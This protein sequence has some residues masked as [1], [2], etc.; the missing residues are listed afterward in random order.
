[1]RTIANDRAVTAWVDRLSEAGG[2]LESVR[3]QILEAV[4]AL[5]RT[6]A[7]CW[8]TT[9]PATLMITGSV[10]QGLP[11]SIGAEFFRIELHEPDYL[12]LV[13]LPERTPPVGTLWSETGGH[14]ED[15]TRWR[16][17]FGPLGLGDEL[18]A[19]FV[20]GSACWGYLSLHRRRE[21]PQFGP[22]EIDVMATLA[23]AAAQALRHSHMRSA[24]EESGTRAVVLLAADRTPLAVSEEAE[25]LMADLEPAA[26]SRSDLPAAVYTAIGHL[27][28]GGSG[29]VTAVGAS[30]TWLVVRAARLT[31]EDAGWT[32]VTI[33]SAS[34][35]EARGHIMASWALT[36]RESEVA[37]M[38]LRGVS[39]RRIAAELFISP[40]TV[41]QHLKK[42][43]EKSGV[44]S[45]RDLVALVNAGS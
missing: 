13:D 4:F 39:T 11:H 37:A 18:R 42:V 41:Q 20:T 44:H 43:F 10:T 1:M 35:R 8:S 12:K 33:E 9:D 30:G 14:L 15:S 29:E 19:A 25:K 40:H 31:G 24:I 2:D 38:V 21:S 34:P 5:I 27:D 16:S 23:A 26:V 3:H 17:L 28:R 32:A 22:E 36:H 7:W 45:R 6:D